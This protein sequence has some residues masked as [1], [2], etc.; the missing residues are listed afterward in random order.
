MKLEIDLPVFNGFY[1]THFECDCESNEIEEGYSYED[2]TWEYSDYHERVS[3]ACCEAVQNKLIELEF[4]CVITYKEIDSP[5]EYNFRNDSIVCELDFKIK[6]LKKF[7]TECDRKDQSPFYYEFENYLEQHFKSRSGFISF[8]EHDVK[9]WVKTYLKKSNE[10][11]DLCL[12]S[13]LTFYL[14]MNDYTDEDLSS[15][16]SVNSE[17]CWISGHLTNEAENE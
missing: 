11:F 17:M 10:T 15:E 2:Y 9:T 8:Y 5:K 14:S 16:E 13:F 1:N 12:S 7:I 4:P 3:R 6:D